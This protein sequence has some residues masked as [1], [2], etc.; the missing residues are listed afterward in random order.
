MS[1]TFL[2]PQ[3]SASTSPADH[4]AT[5]CVLH[6]FTDALCKSAREACEQRERAAHE[7]RQRRER[8]AMRS[9][10]NSCASAPASAR[11]SP[12][13]EPAAP[14]AAP[15][16]VADTGVA[17]EGAARQDGPASPPR[18]AWA[19]GMEVSPNRQYDEEEYY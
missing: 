2:S 11:F 15:A 17:G 6:S 7:E 19:A 16:P 4:L 3:L 5:L 13:E 10:R 1:A 18:T 9:R 12:T 8:E 14:A